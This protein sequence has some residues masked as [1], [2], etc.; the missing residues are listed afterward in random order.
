MHTFY[1][2]CVLSTCAIFKSINYTGIFLFV[3]YELCKKSR[4]N[5]LLFVGVSKLGWGPRLKIFVFAVIIYV[6]WELEQV[7]PGIFDTVFWPVKWILQESNGSLHEWHFRTFLD[8]YSTLFGMIFA[9][10]FP[11]LTSWFVRVERLSPARCAALKTLVGGLFIVL[12][13]KK[14]IPIII[15]IIRII[16]LIRIMISTLSTFSRLLFL[17]NCFVPFFYRLVVC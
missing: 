5:S 7:V 6:V 1:F 8:H 16:I 15:I 17:I 2:L 9:M 13:C 4:K 14:T 11:Y 10:N 12:V 3:L